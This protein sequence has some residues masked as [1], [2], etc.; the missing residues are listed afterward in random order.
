MSRWK[1]F[2]LA[3]AVLIAAC[4]KPSPRPLRRRLPVAQTAVPHYQGLGDH[5]RKVTTSNPEA[6]QYFD[7][8]MAFLFA[9]NH[10]EAIR[11]FKRATELDPACAMAH[12]AISLA[13]GPTSTS[14]S[15]RPI[16][17]RPRG[18]R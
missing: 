9:F 13:N 3:A 17:R 4:N 11:S 12:W 15:S 1:S 6:Q 18:T 7:Q 16:A 2:P 8:G 14:L 10:D 5:T